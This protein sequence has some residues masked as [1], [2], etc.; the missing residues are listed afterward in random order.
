MPNTTSA[1]TRSSAY[2]SACA[3]VARTLPGLVTCARGGSDPTPWA[4]TSCAGLAGTG[5]AGTGLAG[6][7][8][9]GTGAA[10]AF[11]AGRGWS[12]VRAD[13]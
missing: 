12:A 9:A 4:G 13:G 1:P 10:S 7:G 2:T 11:S 8:L 3:P 5:T 6:T